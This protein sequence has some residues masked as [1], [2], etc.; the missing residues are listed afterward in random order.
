MTYNSKSFRFTCPSLF[1]SKKWVPLAASRS[2]SFSAAM[3]SSS[4]P[5]NKCG[6]VKCT[7]LL[8][9]FGM[10]KKN[11][12]VAPIDKYSQDLVAMRR[13]IQS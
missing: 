12:E 3:S 5:S 13:L 1:T 11:G 4:W 8:L 10:F 6:I 9:C 7:M 2:A